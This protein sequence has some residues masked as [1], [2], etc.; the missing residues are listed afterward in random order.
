VISFFSAA[1]RRIVEEEDVFFFAA[2]EEAGFFLEEVPV[3][4][5]D[6]V[7]AGFFDDDVFLEEDEVFADAL[8]I[9]SVIAFFSLKTAVYQKAA[10]VCSCF[11]IRNRESGI[12]A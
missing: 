11:R 6:E 8:V 5:F 3:F 2:V 10:A 12:P 4:L 9:S 1:V 7:E